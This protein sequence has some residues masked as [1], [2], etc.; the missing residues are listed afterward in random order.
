MLNHD[1]DIHSKLQI[2]TQNSKNYFTLF[3]LLDSPTRPSTPQIVGKICSVFGRFSVVSYSLPYNETMMN[4]CIGAHPKDYFVMD[5][6]FG[7][8]I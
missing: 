1:C 2:M 5:L 3:K 8:H 4:E 6:L 7:F